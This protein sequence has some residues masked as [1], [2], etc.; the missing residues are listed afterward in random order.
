MYV[1]R[2]LL[3]SR[4]TNETRFFFGFILN[5]SIS[6]LLNPFLNLFLESAEASKAPF[7]ILILI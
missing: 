2:M 3:V 5:C 4:S 6:L 7:V 1:K